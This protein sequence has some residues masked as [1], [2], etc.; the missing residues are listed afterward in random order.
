VREEE[1]SFLSFFFCFSSLLLLLYVFYLHKERNAARSASVLFNEAMGKFS[2][3]NVEKCLSLFRLAAAKGHQEAIWVVDIEKR[4]EKR[5]GWFM[6]AL[7]FEKTETPLGW[8]LAG[9]LSRHGSARRFDLWRKSAEGGCSW[10]QA[11]Y[12]WF[13]QYGERKDE[14]I[15]VEGVEKA[16][17]QN[18][19]WAMNQL[20]NQFGFY[21]QDK[22]IPYFQAGAELGYYHSMWIL[23]TRLLEGRGCEKDFHQSV[24]YSTL[25][26]NFRSFWRVME[27]ARC[28]INRLSHKERARQ[29]F[30]YDFDQMCYWLGQAMYWRFYGTK[31]WSGQSNRMTAFGNGCLDYYCCCVELQQKSILTFL[32]FWSRT[33]GVKGPGQMIGQMVWEGREE[34]LV[35]EYGDEEDLQ[36]K[37]PPRRSTRLKR[38]KK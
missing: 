26:D 30:G 27:R 28:T 36:E 38:I 33:T 24:V 4:Y 7:A 23:A 31:D 3:R 34:N 20:G 22:A 21:E 5:Y 18:N 25:G 10:G 9:A 6:L 16:A 11:E 19:P 8:Y 13:F 14:K 35:I 1:G 15:F 12:A 29:E 2:S 17:N 32:L 37:P